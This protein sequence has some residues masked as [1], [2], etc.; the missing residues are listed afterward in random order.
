MSRFVR[1]IFATF[2]LALMPLAFATAQ[3]VSV[4]A[5][6]PSSALQGTV[7][8][9]VE[10]TGSGFNNTANVKFFV[11]GTADTGGIT[12]KKVSVG[13]AKKLI[14]TIDI[15]DS[16]VVNKFDIEVALSNGRKG[17]GTTLFAVQAKGKPQPPAPPPPPV[18][19][20]QVSCAGS[21][22]VFPAF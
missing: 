5:A 14:A 12:V 3:Q 2:V 17:K 13:S 9:D 22:G 11:T 15:A 20:E 4:T 19:P 8:L 21:P 16:A 1:S 10:V 7:S 6:D 18:Y